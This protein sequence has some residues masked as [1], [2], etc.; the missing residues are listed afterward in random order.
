MY[1][2]HLNHQAIVYY[3]KTQVSVKDVKM[4]VVDLFSLAINREIT[5][6]W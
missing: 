2:R 3:M 1:L 5:W 6:N 4:V